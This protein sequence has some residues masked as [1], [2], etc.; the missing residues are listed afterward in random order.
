MMADCETEREIKLLL[1]DHET[2]FLSDENWLA[3]VTVQNVRYD[4]AG[5]ELTTVDFFGKALWLRQMGRTQAAVNG[6]IQCLAGRPV[7]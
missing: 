6:P 2:F 7:F 4:S 3:V 5:C 1:I